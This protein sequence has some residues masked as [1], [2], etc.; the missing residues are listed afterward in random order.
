MQL[1]KGLGSSFEPIR[2]TEPQPLIEANNLAVDAV[3]D[4]SP[5]GVIGP[6]VNG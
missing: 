5:D 4:T 1:G 3:I 2:E 6:M